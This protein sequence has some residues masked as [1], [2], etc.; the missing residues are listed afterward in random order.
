M[1]RWFRRPSAQ[2]LEIERLT[3][4]LE[5]KQEELAGI[6]PT[7]EFAKYF[8]LERNVNKLSDDLKAIGKHLL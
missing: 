2:E 6:S 7:N 4:E 1:L 3:A 5:Q 8:R